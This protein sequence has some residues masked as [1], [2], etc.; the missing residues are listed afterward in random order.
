MPD[1]LK[2]L[3]LFFS[4]HRLVLRTGCSRVLQRLLLACG[5]LATVPVP[6]AKAFMHRDVSGELEWTSAALQGAAGQGAFSESWV[7]QAQTDVSLLARRKTDFELQILSG[8]TIISRDASQAIEKTLNSFLEKKDEG[9]SSSQA[10]STAKA[11]DEVRS[12]FGKTLTTQFHTNLLSPRIGR[13]GIAPYASGVLD[14]VIDNAA[15]PKLDASAGGYAGVLLSYAQALGKDFDVGLALRPGVGGYKRYALDLSMFGD[16]ISGST[17]SQS[18]DDLGSFP[19]AVYIPLDLAAAW[20]VGAST[21]VHM[22]SK[23]TFDATPLSQMNGSAGAILNRINLGFSQQ[24]P[25]SGSKLQTLQVGGELQDLSGLKNGWNELLIRTQWAGRYAVRLPFRDQTS[26]AINAG[27]K[28]GY[29]V[30]SLFL[31][32]IVGK[33]EVAL[34]ARENGAYSGQRVNRLQ[35]I[36]FNSQMRF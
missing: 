6:V 31:D 30:V 13:V 5:L 18:L 21:R 29:P 4:G 15:W 36:S 7:D 3:E 19:T 27:L 16:F 9:A 8:T 28:S 11:L 20:W 25:L 35:T 1:N 32:F 26:F 22:V 17:N 34:S 10:Q 24:I 23:N 14:A 33:L 2:S 12:V